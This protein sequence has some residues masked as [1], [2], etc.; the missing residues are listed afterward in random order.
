MR[1]INLLYDYERNYPNVVWSY[2]GCWGGLGYFK[3]DRDFLARNDSA[4]FVEFMQLKYDAVNQFSNR[5]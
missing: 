1:L 2:L 3:M 5:K 4:R